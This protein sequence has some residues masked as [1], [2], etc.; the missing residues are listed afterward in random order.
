MKEAAR[1][2]RNSIHVQETE[3]RRMREEAR[4]LAQEVDNAKLR[5]LPKQ[6]IDI[7]AALARRANRDAQNKAQEV[8]QL[9]SRDRLLREQES[10]AATQFE[11]AMTELTAKREVKR[12]IDNMV[13]PGWKARTTAATVPYTL[14]P[15]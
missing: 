13:V 11:K 15:E 6:E 14:S 1:N 12:L 10:D 9:K 7:R 8:A 5:E 3:L 4:N 2:R